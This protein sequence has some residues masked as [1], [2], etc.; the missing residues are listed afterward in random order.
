MCPEA[1]KEKPERKSDD[2]SSELTT[3]QYL[4]ET[5]KQLQTEVEDLKQELKRIKGVPFGKIGLAFIIP[6]ALALIFSIYNNSNI[7]AFIGLGLT[8][9]EPRAHGNSSH[10]RFSTFLKITI[11]KRFLTK[12]FPSLL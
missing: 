11:K 9:W 7:L 10:T 3:A 6:G 12:N 8:F 2:K 4:V 1:K 5:I